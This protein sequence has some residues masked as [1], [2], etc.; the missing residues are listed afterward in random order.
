MFTQA[1][2][3]PIGG[4]DEGTGWARRDGSECALVAVLIGFGWL[5]VLPALAQTPADPSAPGLHGGGPVSGPPGAP[6]TPGG[7]PVAVPFPAPIGPTLSVTGTALVP[8]SPSS[9]GVLFVS[10]QE[11]ATGSDPRAAVAAARARVAKLRATLMAAGIPAGA[12]EETD[13]SAGSGVGGPMPLA[14][15]NPMAMPTPM[16]LPMP[17][18][19]DVPLRV[20]PDSPSS[21]GPAGGAEGVP[22]GALRDPRSGVGPAIFPPIRPPSGVVVRASLQVTATSVEQLTNA[23][24]L[25]IDS[26]AT[27]VSSH[28]GGTGLAPDAAALASAASRATAQARGMAQASAAAA[29]VTLAAV[30]S[31][32]VM[33]PMPSYGPSPTPMWQVQVQMTYGVR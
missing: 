20:L 22:S 15:P 30:Q 27:E 4:A 32:N 13:F 11:E 3:R 7:Q 1:D 17:P 31:V 23:F 8:G 6:S 28:G 24:Q 14:R 29:G 19:Q 33:A 5:G 10:V 16:P 25:A 26:G 18:A 21:T 2:P 9:G 12:I